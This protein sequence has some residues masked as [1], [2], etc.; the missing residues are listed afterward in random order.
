MSIEWLGGKDVIETGNSFLVPEYASKLI[1]SYIKYGINDKDMLLESICFGDNI[2]KI[3]HDKHDHDDHCERNCH[4]S[5]CCYCGYKEL[6]QFLI[7]PNSIINND[8]KLKAIAFPFSK[9]IKVLVAN[10]DLLQVDVVDYCDIKKSGKVGLKTKDLLGFGDNKKIIKDIMSINWDD[11]EV[12]ILGHCNL[13]SSLSNTDW[14]SFIVDLAKNNNKYIYSFDSFD[15]DYEKFI[16]PPM[17]KNFE[18]NTFDKLWQINAP[19]LGIFGTSSQQGKFSLQLNL[20]RK[21]LEEGYKLQQI[22]TEPTGSLFGIEYTCP[23]GYNASIILQEEK[24]AMFFNDIMNECAAKEP[25]IIIAGCQS[26]TISHNMYH[27]SQL[28]FKP[29]E[30]LIGTMPDAVVLLINKFDEI[31]YIR[32]TISFIEAAVDCTVVACVISPVPNK[33]MPA[34][35]NSCEELS[36]EINKPVYQ[37][38]DI[39]NIFV[40]IDRKSTRLN[41]SH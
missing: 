20:R 16:S 4:E 11:F 22:S 1:N 13:I 37:F 41:S 23:I 18:N 15:L 35:F 28:L 19:V 25:D 39:E 10:E 33:K 3:D 30:F 6:K 32:R 31:S 21:F 8:K 7:P 40:S 38:D 17:I 2:L 12:V 24:M 34:L 14:F 36:A 26:G 9:E 29:Y 5:H 27:S